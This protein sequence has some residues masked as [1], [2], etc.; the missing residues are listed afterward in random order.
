MLCYN[1]IFAPFPHFHLI[2]I[3]FLKC[4]M[5]S[6][7]DLGMY[8]STTFFYRVQF[9]STRQNFKYTNSL[10]QPCYFRYLSYR[11]ACEGKSESRSVVSD[12]W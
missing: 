3:A 1:L 12:F 6:P 4:I 9:S 7:I 8:V 11:Y 10:T 5:L 2:Y